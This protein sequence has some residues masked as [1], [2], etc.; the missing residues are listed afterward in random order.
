MISLTSFACKHSLTELQC[1]AD[2]P[3]SECQHFLLD[4]PR[5]PLYRIRRLLS[6]PHKLIQALLGLFGSLIN[7]AA[8][9]RCS[10]SHWFSS[11]ECFTSPT[12]GWMVSS[13]SSEG[14]VAKAT[15]DAESG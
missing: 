8:H 14:S 6:G 9:F 5:I 15:L 10:I 2:I 11:S 12:Q 13:S 7:R 3:F 1:G 4:V